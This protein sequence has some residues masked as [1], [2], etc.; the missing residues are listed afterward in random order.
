MIHRLR[1]LLAI[2]G[3]IGLCPGAGT[4]RRG[5]RPVL[6]RLHHP[7]ADV[8]RDL[9][10]QAR[11]VR[12]PPDHGA[13]RS[14]HDR[15]VH[16][17]VAGEPPRHRRQCVMGRSG[18]RARRRSH[19]NGPVRPARDLRLQLR[20]P[21]RDDRRHRRRRAR[22]VRRRRGRVHLHRWDG[23]GRGP[24]D[25]GAR[26]LRGPRL[27]ARD[28][29]APASARAQQTSL[30]GA[31]LGAL[32]V[33]P[34]RDVRRGT[35]RLAAQG[36]GVAGARRDRLGGLGALERSCRWACVGASLSSA[37]VRGRLPGRR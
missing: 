9:D 13:R 20:A 4:R 27:G 29:P 23:P 35:R 19:A 3:L 36:L 28:H 33:P 31:L 21:P 30:A 25:V 6:P 18:R 8:G 5:R 7:G 17:R 16:E 34:G 24:R 1:T 26:G 37:P 12:L 11:A 14:G 15:H 2:G 22:P 32:E 10:R